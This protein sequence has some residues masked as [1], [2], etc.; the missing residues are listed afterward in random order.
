[1]LFNKMFPYFRQI[2]HHISGTNVLLGLITYFQLHN[3]LNRQLQRP[4]QDFITCCQSKSEYK[5]SLL[6]FLQTRSH[7]VG[8]CPVNLQC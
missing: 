5:N 6:S 7:D 2:F 4:L 3:K 8:I 1:M